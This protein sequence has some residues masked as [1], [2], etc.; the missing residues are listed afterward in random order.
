MAIK[1]EICWA[2]G[3]TGTYDTEKYHRPVSWH[4]K[5]IAG[6]A[7]M[8]CQSCCR[9][10]NVEGQMS[11]IL[12]EEVESRHGIRLDEKGVPLT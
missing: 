2:C 10:L 6:G 5:P 9:L 11:H 3:D 8:L 12:I 7:H 1:T 4:T